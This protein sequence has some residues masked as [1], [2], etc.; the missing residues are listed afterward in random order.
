MNIIYLFIRK[1]DYLAIFSSNLFPHMDEETGSE[2]QTETCEKGQ[3]CITDYLIKIA[4]VLTK[5]IISKIA[6]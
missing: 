6:E 2:S 5:G 4:T 1:S 3:H